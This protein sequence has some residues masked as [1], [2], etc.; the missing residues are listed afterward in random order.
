M[1]KKQQEKNWLHLFNNILSVVVL[2]LALYIILLPLLP[3]IQFWVK[4]TT[5]A[6]PRLVEQNLPDQPKGQPD[7]EVIP[8]DNTLVIPSLGLQEVVYEGSGPAALSKG[9]W[10]RP[11]TSDPTQ[12]SN[13]VLVGHRFTY[14]DPQGVFYHLD[15]VKVGDRIVLYWEG[16]KYAYTVMKAFV[17]AADK[18]EIEAPTDSPILTIYTCTPLWSARDRLVIQAEPEE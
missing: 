16:E 11:H 1:T 15:K 8:A 9:I 18:I 10:R 14:T 17:V 2:L 3:N 6:Y 5:N 7:Q 4:K 13:T 12:G